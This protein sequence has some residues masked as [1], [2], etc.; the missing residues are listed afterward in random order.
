M[1]PTNGVDLA[2]SQDVRAATAGTQ[3]QREVRVRI[4]SAFA[5]RVKTTKQGEVGS[6]LPPLKGN[7]YHNPGEKPQ[8]GGKIHL[9]MDLNPILGGVRT[10]KKG[11]SEYALVKFPPVW[12]KAEDENG[13]PC[14]FLFEV[15]RDSV[16]SINVTKYL[17]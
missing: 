15:S 6:K 14:V 4:S 12:V 1:T 8:E 16:V 11:D 10:T 7:A 17:E 9:T 5:G 3:E 2:P 13:T